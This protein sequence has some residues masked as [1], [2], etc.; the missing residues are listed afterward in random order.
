MG[1][2]SGGPFSSQPSGLRVFWP[3]ALS[4]IEP[5]MRSSATT[6]RFSAGKPYKFSKRA[7]FFRLNCPLKQ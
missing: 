2:R 4:L 7:V 3:A 1:L 6:E 5:K